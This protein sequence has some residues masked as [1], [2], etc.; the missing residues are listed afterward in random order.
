MLRLISITLTFIF[1]LIASGCEQSLEAP[2]SEAEVNADR[3]VTASFN[4]H[5]NRSRSSMEATRDAIAIADEV[6]EPLRLRGFRS[7]RESSQS[8]GEVFRTVDRKARSQLTTHR[9]TP[10]GPPLARQIS[11]IVLHSGLLASS[12]R[13]VLSEEERSDAIRYYLQTAI[14]NDGS[15][16]ETQLKALTVLESD[17]SAEVESLA[18]RALSNLRGYKEALRQPVEVPQWIRQ[19]ATEEQV[20]ELQR[21][22]AK[23]RRAR[24]NRLNNSELESQLATLAGQL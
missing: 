9:G 17:Y 22:N 12:A 21:E 18:R 3:A 2:V 15:D 23:S 5:M 1:L 7:D 10:V 4:N 24:L 6:T 14:E 20:E 13:D 16:F 19:E 8:A 11:N